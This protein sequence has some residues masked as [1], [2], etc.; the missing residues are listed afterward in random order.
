MLQYRVNGAQDRIGM[1]MGFVELADGYHF[2][3]LKNCL[4]TGRPSQASPR[5][6]CVVDEQGPPLAIGI[7]SV[8][9]T[10]VFI[11]ESDQYHVML[12]DDL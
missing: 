1:A 7:G 6:T 5:V 4:Q 9:G 2:I 10:M 12:H 3:M 8:V 11:R